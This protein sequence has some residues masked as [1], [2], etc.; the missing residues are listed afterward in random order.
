M[1]KGVYEGSRVSAGR[2]CLKGGWLSAACRIL[3]VGRRQCWGSRVSTGRGCLERGN[4][5]VV[6]RG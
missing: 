1:G 6:M 3:K 4:V 5:V 2:G